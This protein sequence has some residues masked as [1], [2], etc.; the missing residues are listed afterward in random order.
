MPL[1]TLDP[2]SALIIIDLQKGI[3]GRQLPIPIEPVIANSAA[4]AQAFR[5]H[6]LPVVLVNVDAGAPGRTE[7]RRPNVTPPA[8]WTEIVPQLGQTDGDIVVTKKTWGVFLSTDLD[9]QLKALG[10]TQVVLTGV[11][12]SA[13]VESSAR[14]AH[15]LGYN[16]ALVTDAMADMRAETHEH[17][18]AH[19]FPRLGETGTTAELLA[20][21]G[22]DAA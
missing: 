19:I 15:G 5:A 4:L 7:A 16:V 22:K 8:D 18:V 17:S 12:T 2:K 10:V 6:G 20:L 1:S 13:G 14:E 9:A 11:A 3:V 21:L